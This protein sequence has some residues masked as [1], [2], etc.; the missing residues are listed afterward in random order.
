M[1]RLATIIVVLLMSINA[2]ALPDSYKKTLQQNMEI[3][4]NSKTRYI[5]GA[6]GTEKDGVLQLDC[7]GLIFYI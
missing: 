4:K 1:T 5:W 6:A 2:Y 7:S 3:V